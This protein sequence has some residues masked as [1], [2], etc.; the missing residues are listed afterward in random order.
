MKERDT[1]KKAQREAGATLAVLRKAK[2]TEQYEM[3]EALK[4]HPNPFMDTVLLQLLDWR[5]PNVREA[6]M[7]ALLVRNEAL[8]RV[9]ARA[10]LGDPNGCARNAAAEILGEFGKQQDI[11]RLRRA[12]TGD[13]WVMRATV[14]DSL[15]QI[16]GKSAHSILQHTLEHDPNPVVRRDTAYALSYAQSSKMIPVLEQALAGE[17][18]EQARV[19]LLHGLVALGQRERLSEL[20]AMLKSEDS[21]VRYATIN[22]IRE[23]VRPE[24]RKQIVQAI[25]AM[26]ETEENPG[27]KSDATTVVEEISRLIGTE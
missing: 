17:K 16:G 10:L 18:E 15:G 20:L 14:A 2:W 9:A 25:R 12:L 1:M 3:I 27:L 21:S 23:D 4:S 24:D 7:E 11:H 22:S 5:T 19:G 26:L 13:E 6:A 8:G